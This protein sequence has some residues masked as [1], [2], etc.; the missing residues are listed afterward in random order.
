MERAQNAKGMEQAKLLQQIIAYE[1]PGPGGF[2]DDLG[3]YPASS[4]VLRGYPM[5][6]ANPMNEAAFGKP[7]ALAS[8]P[9][10]TRRMNRRELLCAM[11]TWTRK[12]PTASG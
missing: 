7:I 8:V 2:Y 12:R 10:T 6:M 3:R 1:D 9:C 11:T 5:I 4:R